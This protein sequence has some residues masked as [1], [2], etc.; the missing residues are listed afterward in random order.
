MNAM[1]IAENRIHLYSRVPAFKI[2]GRSRSDN[3]SGFVPDQAK[4]CSN[5]DRCMTKYAYIHAG[6]YSRLRGKKLLAK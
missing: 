2:N 6:D 1:L 3:L 5:S 4:M